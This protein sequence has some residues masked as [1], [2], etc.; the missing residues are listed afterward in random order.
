MT[1]NRRR[2]L[3][4]A[5]LAGASAML[6]SL[7][8]RAQGMTP[9]K[10]LVVLFSSG[11]AHCRSLNLR[12]PGAPAAWSAY[13]LYD[14]ATNQLVP[15][16]LEFEFDLTGLALEDFSP[17]LAPLYAHRSKM[18]VTE[19]LAYL[20]SRYEDGDAHASAHLA[21]LTG[22]YGAYVYD[23]V[24]CHGSHPSIDQLISDHIRATEN[25][26]HDPLA[27]SLPIYGGRYAIDPFHSSFYRWS[28]ASQTSVDRVPFEADPQVAFN[29]I[30]QGVTPDGE[31]PS[32]RQLAQDDV[33][34]RVSAHYASLLPKL[35]LADRQRLD[36][37][38]TM[39]LELQQGLAQGPVL[40]CQLPPAPGPVG[41][42]DEAMFVEDLNHWFD[43]T[44]AAFSCDLTRVVSIRD[45]Q[46][47][48]SS[49]VGVD[50]SVDWHH[51]IDH[52]S[53][54]NQD[55]DVPL[56]PEYTAAAQANTAL[57]VQQAQWVAQLC[58]RLDAIPEADGSTM[59][60]N[61]LVLWVKEMSHGNHGHEHYHTVMLGNVGGHFN[62]GRY[63][64]YAQNNPNPWNRNYNNEY[65]GTPYNHYL[66]SILQ[67]FGLSQNHMGTVQSVQG[68]VPHA[69]ITGTIDMT[70]P[71]PRLT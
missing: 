27:F 24:K 49:L 40:G 34:N 14:Y 30:F 10:R 52:H 32:P 13:D 22:A 4:A 71:L 65:T 61:T 70:G 41:A 12:P 47:A 2:F 59:L 46:W 18:I 20:S 60:D 35:S 57:D 11:G 64:K 1:F 8:L 63:I 44:A 68:S 45:L 3:Q 67:A 54:P 37:H 42:T 43:I 36:A 25:P 51:A 23:E 21:C 53:G 17:T 26:L 55:Y 66:V 19:G 29:R 7:S 62:T 31:M 15:D 69:N 6:P 50:T 56:D 39:L 28:D 33:F 38:R 9:P 58:D 5:G 16:D 48:P